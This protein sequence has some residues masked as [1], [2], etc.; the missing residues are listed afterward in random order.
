MGNLSIAHT[1]LGNIAMTHCLEPMAGILFSCD[2]QLF[3]S[4]ENF[5]R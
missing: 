2:L 4:T 3:M 1:F 5:T